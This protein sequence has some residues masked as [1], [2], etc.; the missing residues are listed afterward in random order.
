[1]NR[2]FTLFREA[3]RREPSRRVL[4]G[5]PGGAWIRF[6]DLHRRAERL[7]ARLGR[8]GLRRGEVVLIRIGKMRKTPNDRREDFDDVF[9]FETALKHD[10]KISPP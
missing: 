4:C 2:L 7:G 10:Y 8:A 3:A 1:M 5:R 6:A 9:D